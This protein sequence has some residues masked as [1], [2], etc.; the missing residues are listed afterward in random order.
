MSFGLPEI[1]VKKEE[2]FSD[3]FDVFAFGKPHM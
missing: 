3:N 2:F 1:A